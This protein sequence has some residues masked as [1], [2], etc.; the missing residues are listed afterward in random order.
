MRD[1]AG[2]VWSE[3]IDIGGID[4]AELAEIPSEALYRAIDRVYQ[5]TVEETPAY[6]RFDAAI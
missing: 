2:R 1:D 3:I 6:Q 5:E 4:P